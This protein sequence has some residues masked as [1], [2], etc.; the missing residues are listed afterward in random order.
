MKTKIDF[1]SSYSIRLTILS[2]IYMKSYNPMHIKQQ[3]ATMNTETRVIIV[4]TTSYVNFVC[5]FLFFLD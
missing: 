4:H 2:I 5:F 3:L 1:D